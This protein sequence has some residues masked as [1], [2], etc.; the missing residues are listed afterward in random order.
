MP[1][2]DADRNKRIKV[3]IFGS[4]VYQIEFPLTCQH[5]TTCAHSASD[6]NGL[7]CQLVVYG[8]ERMV[9]GERPRGA[10]PMDEQSLQFSVDQ[11]LLNF[12]N[13]VRYVVNDLHVE[14]IGRAIEHF[15]ESLPCQESHAATV[16]PCEI[17]GCRG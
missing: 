2:V 3:K 1:K 12:G 9:R 15:P 14:V 17:S 8:Y 13:I 11:V 5:V 10:L 6:E 7:A 16:D 4:Q